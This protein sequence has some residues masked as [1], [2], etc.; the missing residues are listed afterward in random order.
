M[1][2]PSLEM[3]RGREFYNITPPFKQAKSAKGGEKQI[4]GEKLFGED[5][6]IVYLIKIST[7]VFLPHSGYTHRMSLENQ[8]I[9]PT[10]IIVIS[11]S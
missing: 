9:S 11:M 1:S 7:V 4:P 10:F 3:Y 5:S 8:E 2:G 6:A